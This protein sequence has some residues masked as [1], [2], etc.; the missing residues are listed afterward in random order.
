MD[1]ALVRDYRVLVVPGLHGSGPAHWQSRWEQ[2]F[3]W[4]ERVVQR[5]WDVPDLQAWSRRIGEVLRESARPA[6][7]VAHSFG[8]LATIHR[9]GSE[10]HRLAGALLVAPADPVKFGIADILRHR[11][12]PCPAILVGSLD[13]PWMEASRAADWAAAWGCG[14]INAGKR[15]HINADSGLG[16]WDA[17]LG[18]LELVANRF[19][20]D[21]CAEVHN[22]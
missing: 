20:S 11:T 21:W 18:L 19:T 15:G 3:P 10:A 13:D 16:D 6:L 17:G 9:A 1:A 5:D 2:R 8:C 22:K 14:Y 12:M 4:F 7:V